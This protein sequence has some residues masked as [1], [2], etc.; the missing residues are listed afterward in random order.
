MSTLAEIVKNVLVIIIITSFLEMMLPEG[1]IKPFVRF[2]IGLFIIITV[3]NPVLGFF[4][5]EHKLEIEWWDART[6]SSAP[7]R[8]DQAGKELNQ[9]IM[10]VNNQNLQEKV[11]G[12]VSAV[13]QLVPGV[14]R[15]KTTAQ[16]DQQGNL[17]SLKVVITPDKRRTDPAGNEDPAR[18]T[19][20]GPGKEAHDLIKSKVLDLLNNIYGFNGVNK[21]ILI[22]GG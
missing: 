15:V 5:E 13:A 9:Q 22:E 21:E 12:Q 3:L 16:L 6:A 10:S 7:E 17:T 18:L 1:G 20:T 2:A 4:F 11:E 19:G 14:E 8:I